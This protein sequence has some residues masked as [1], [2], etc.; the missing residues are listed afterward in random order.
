MSDQAVVLTKWLSIQGIIFVKGQ[1][2][3][4][5]ILNYSLFMIFSPVANF[6]HHPLVQSIY[7]P[8]SA[9]Y[10]GYFWKKK[11]SYHMS[12]VHSLWHQ[13]MRKNAEMFIYKWCLCI[14]NPSFINESSKRIV[15]YKLQPFF[16]QQTCDLVLSWFRLGLIWCRLRIWVSFT[17]VYTFRTVIAYVFEH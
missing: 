9:N 7:I 4:S 1:L 15:P 12:I 8:K 5:Y 6:G 10:L 11:H 14:K 16:C 13:M 2:D 17:L 3:H